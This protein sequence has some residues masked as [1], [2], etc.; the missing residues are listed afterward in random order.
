[1]VTHDF[2]CSRCERVFE[3]HLLLPGTVMHLD[4]GGSLEI[5]WRSTVRRPA[6][7]PEAESTAVYYSEKENQY[8][9]PGQ[10]DR[11]VPDYLKRRGYE[12]VWLRSD[13]AVGK[14][15]REQKVMNE[16]RHWDRNGRGI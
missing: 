3:S 6:A 11:P 15:E 8:Q 14:F 9:Y 16:R 4:C 5:L 10:N 1:M 2:I 7:L 13:A 12:K